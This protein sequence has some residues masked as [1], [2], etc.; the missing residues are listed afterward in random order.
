MVR[1]LDAEEGRLP[2]RG[3]VMKPNWKTTTETGG[4]RKEGCK[5]GWEDDMWREKAV[6]REKGKRIRAWLVQQYMNKPHTF[7]KGARKEQMTW[8][9]PALVIKLFMK[10]IF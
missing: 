1:S 5:K 9:K 10:G 4:L 2:K 6:N 3:E 8:Q 7:T